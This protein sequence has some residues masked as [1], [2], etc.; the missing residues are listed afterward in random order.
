M[1]YSLIP[2]LNRAIKYLRHCGWTSEQC[3]LSLLVRAR[4]E[5]IRLR[6]KLEDVSD[7]SRSQEALR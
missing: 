3:P 2:D 4:D 1:N 5:I 6:K 7:K